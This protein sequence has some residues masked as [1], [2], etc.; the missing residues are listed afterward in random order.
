MPLEFID[1]FWLC[2][3]GVKTLFEFSNKLSTSSPNTV[4]YQCIPTE[5]AEAGSLCLE[6]PFLECVTALLLSDLC[7]IIFTGR[8]P[9]L[10]WIFCCCFCT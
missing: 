3:Q 6:I 9:L 5:K 8:F 7:A 1:F 4:S 2:E 10:T